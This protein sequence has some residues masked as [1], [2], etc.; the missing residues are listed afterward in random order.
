MARNG[1]VKTGRVPRYARWDRW[2]RN[3]WRATEKLERRIGTRETIVLIHYHRVVRWVG[4]IVVNLPHNT[5]GEIRRKS[6]RDCGASGT[7]DIGTDTGTKRILSQRVRNLGISETMLLRV[8]SRSGYNARNVNNSDKWKSRV[9]VND[10]NEVATGA[11]LRKSHDAAGCRNFI[12]AQIATARVGERSSICG[13][14]APGDSGGPIIIG[15]GACGYH[16][17]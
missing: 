17:C 11:V 12:T 8:G 16:S 1:R 6:C 3:A 2:T 9:S 4:A 14:H 10:R 15:R 13:R 7:Q 5:G